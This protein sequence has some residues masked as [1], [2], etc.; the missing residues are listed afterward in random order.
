MSLKAICPS[1][2]SETS[3]LYS[4]LENGNPCPYCGLPADVI[5]T[6]RQAQSRHADEQLLTRLM[7]AEKRAAK[8]EGEVAELKRMQAAVRDA[9]EADYSPVDW[10]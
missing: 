4:A 10:N 8:A 9:L 5:E 6:V 2:D 1:C 7:E 3:A